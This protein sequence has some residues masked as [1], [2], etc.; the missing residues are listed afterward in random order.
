MSEKNLHMWGSLAPC[1]CK[2]F[3][4]T[5]R[6][7]E[8]GSHTRRCNSILTGPLLRQVSAWSDARLL[9]SQHQDA[10]TPV[11]FKT[12]MSIYLTVMANCSNNGEHESLTNTRLYIWNKNFFL[13]QK[14]K[15]YIQKGPGIYKPIPKTKWVENLWWNQN[16]S[17]LLWRRAIR[18]HSVSW[19]WTGR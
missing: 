10:P 17:P 16:I 12:Q 19:R 3:V 13:K 6:I 8:I 18:Q 7:C 2:R 15:G 14:N 5:N 9:N 1:P 4:K 11:L